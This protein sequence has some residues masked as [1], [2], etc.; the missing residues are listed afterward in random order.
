MN[1]TVPS[2]ITSSKYTI[3]GGNISKI[4]AGTTASTLLSGINEGIHCKVYKGNSV[5]SGSTAAGTGMIVKI[6][7][8]S[9]VKASY[10]IIV[11]GDTNGDGNITVTDMIA[12]KAHVLKKTLLSGAVAT[13]ADTN[14]Y[15]GFSITDFIQV[16]AKIL[17]KGTITAR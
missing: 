13:A 3:S 14:G 1:S 6:M 17:G 7:D 8:N 9:A 5:V 2:S 11:T 10:I 16:K 15:G 12:I 4:A